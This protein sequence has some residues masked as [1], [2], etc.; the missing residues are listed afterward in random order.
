MSDIPKYTDEQLRAGVEFLST[1]FRGDPFLGA[2]GGLALSAAEFPK[3]LCQLRAAGMVEIMSKEDPNYPCDN[4]GKPLG[5]K[6]FYYKILPE[7]GG[8][9]I[10]ADLPVA[11]RTV[12]KKSVVSKV[13]GLPELVASQR[14]VIRL[15]KKNSILESEVEKLREQVAVLKAGGSLTDA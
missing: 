14:E 10:V 9:S 1:K 11:P 15:M 5:G 12:T 2:P 7:Q 13:E 6:D 8:R 3:M 4:E